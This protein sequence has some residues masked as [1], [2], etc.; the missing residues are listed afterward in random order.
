MRRTFNQAR[1]ILRNS[2][3]LVDE[4][5]RD[6]EQICFS[7]LDLEIV[8]FS[9]QH[10]YYRCTS[11]IQDPA[12]LQFHQLSERGNSRKYVPGYRSNRKFI[13]Q[14]PK[15]QVLPR[16]VTG[17]SAV[18]VSKP[19]LI[20]IWK[21]ARYFRVSSN[22]SD[23]SMEAVCSCGMKTVLANRNMDSVTRN[24]FD[25]SMGAVCLQNRSRPK[26]MD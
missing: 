17:S 13:Y 24:L 11:P 20:A 4:H 8:C 22:F 3:W 5:V 25:C 18:A 10:V 14:I 6:S 26:R 1:I 12:N 2:P 19:F 16:R 7:T 15:R 21:N 9:R 23:C